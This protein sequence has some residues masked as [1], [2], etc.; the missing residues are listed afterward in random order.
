MRHTLAVVCLVLAPF[1]HA[2]DQDVRVRFHLPYVQPADDTRR[3]DVYSPEGDNMPVIVWVHGGA[4][5]GGDKSFAQHKPR[6]FTR[7]GFVFVAI[8]YR[9]VP[10]VRAGDQAADVAAAIGYVRKNCKKW[11]GD[12]TKVFV[13]GHSAG[14][15]LAALVCTNERYTAAANLKLSDISGC[16]AVDVA[17]YDIPARYDKAGDGLRKTLAEIF[18]E[19]VDERARLSPIRH[20]AAG[21][22]IPPFLI[23]HIGVDPQKSQ[24]E[25]FAEKL[26]QAGVATTLYVARGKG[27]KKL[28]EEMG[29]PDSK[30]SQAVYAFLEARLKKPQR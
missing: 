1:L 16:I 27:H 11:G 29:R 6:T 14:T 20:V 24:S 13:M 4:W 8:N 25:A 28:D 30:A 9:L 18:G 10:N 12:P 5:V 7:R 26:K 22:G 23:I 2:D 15:H 21:K 19:S 3:L 17:G